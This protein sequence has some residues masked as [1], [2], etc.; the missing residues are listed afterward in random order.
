VTSFAYC[1]HNG[2]PRLRVYIYMNSLTEMPSS[3][4]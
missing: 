2:R 4:I 3:G 1:F